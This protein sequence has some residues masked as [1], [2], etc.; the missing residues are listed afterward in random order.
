MSGSCR[1]DESYIK[2][3]GGWKYLYRAMDKEGK[4]VDFLL[5]ARRDKAAAVRFFEP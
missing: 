4:T 2:V 3:K 1:T 5:T